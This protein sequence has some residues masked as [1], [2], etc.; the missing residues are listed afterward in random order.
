MKNKNIHNKN[1][2]TKKLIHKIQ[3]LRLKQ[4]K[5]AQNLININQTP[6]LKREKFSKTHATQ[7]MKKKN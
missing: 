6:E 7:K 5:N 3:H 2:I 1:P 4:T